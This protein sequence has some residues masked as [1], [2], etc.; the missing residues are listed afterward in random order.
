VGTRGLVPVDANLLVAIKLYASM[1]NLSP[2]LIAAVITVESS[3]NPRTIGQVGEIGLMQVRPEYHKHAKG[4]LFVPTYN[5]KEGAKRLAEAKR[6]CKHKID[7]QWVV[8]YNRGLIG[9]ARLKDP[10]TD[11]YYLK[12]RKELSSENSPL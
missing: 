6:Y 12:V 8:C 1:F 2:N 4:L 7:Y 10:S 9:G 3:Q 11:S 5:I